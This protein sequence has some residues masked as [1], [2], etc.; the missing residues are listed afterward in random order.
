MKTTVDTEKKTNSM[1]LVGFWV[2]LFSFVFSFR[3]LT[4]LCACIFNIV[5][6]CTFNPETEKGK[7]FA[8]WGLILGIIS[9][10]FYL[11]MVILVRYLLRYG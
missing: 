7:G 5:A 11:A 2:S 4:I 3:G 8:I 9:G 6:L 1:A 10:I